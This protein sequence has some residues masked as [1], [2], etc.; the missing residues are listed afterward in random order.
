M[1]KWKKPL[2]TFLSASLVASLLVP[3]LPSATKAATNASDLIISEYIEGSSFNKAIELYNGTGKSINLSDYTL[4]LHTNGA[5]TADKKLS[6][7]GTLENGKTFV[8]HHNDAHAEIKGKGDLA[9][10]AVINFNGDD[11]VVL[12]KS[13]EVIDSIGQIDVK[14]NFATDVTLVRKSSITSGD[15][16]LNDPFDPTEWTKYLKDT[17]TNLGSHEMDAGDSTPVENKVEMV[18]A[19]T[20]S[21]SVPMDT[22]ITLS[23]NTEEATIYYTIDG[24]DPT[25]SSTKYT[26][27]VVIDKDVTIKAIAVANGLEN[28]EIATFEYKVLS[29]KTIAEVRTLPI[30]QAALTSGIVTAVFPGAINTTVYIQ[31]ETA[32]IVLYGPGLAVD[33]GDEV[34]VNGKLTEYQSL[35][36]LEVSKDD[37]TILGKKDVPATNLLSA[38]QLKEDKEGMLVSIKHVTVESVSSGNYTAKDENGTSF[39]IRPVDAAHLTIGTKY[40]SITGVLGSFKDTYQLLPRNVADI[41]EDATAVQPV[42]ATPGE[43][44]VKTGDAITLSSGTEDATIYYTTDGKQPTTDSKVYNEPIIITEDMTIKTFSMKDGVKSSVSTFAYAI[45]KGE[46]RIHDIQG[47]GHT[48]PYKDQNVTDIEGIITYVEDANNFY[49]QDQQ[50]DNDDNTSEGILVY[51]KAHNFKVGDVVK[52]SGQVKEFV[53]A[54]YAEKATTDLA[55]TEINATSVTIVT[56]GQTLPKP[57]VIGKDRIPPTEGIDSDGL[58][59]FNPE[60]DGIDFYESLEGMLVE[61]ESPK[62]VAPQQYGELVV[63][64]GNLPTNTTAGGL[65]FTETDANPER[66][67][68]LINDKNYV[69]K[70]GDSFNG[71]VTG[72]VSYS[73]SNYKILTNKDQLPNL[74]DGKTTREVTA[75]KEDSQKLSIASYNVENFSTQTPDSKVKNIAE[76]IINNLKKPDIIG[77]TEMQDND[78]ETDSGTTIANASAKKLTDKIKALGGPE[79]KYIDIAPEDKKDGGAPGGNIRVA[80]L[81]NPERVTLTPGTPGKATNSV[82]YK[83][84]KLTLNPGRIDP[85][86]SA[87]NS[88]RKPLAAQFEFQGKSVIVV[89]NHFNS[90][91]GDQPLFGKNQPPV[92]SSEVQRLKIASIVNNFVKGIKSQDANANVI[93]LGD[94][95]DFEFSKPLTTLKGNE[96]TNMIEKVPFDKRY[97][98]T[99]QGNSQV[100]DHILVS[101]NIAASTDVDIVH[102]NSSF[103]EQH[104][105]ASDHDPVLIQT[106]LS[107]TEAV[108]PIV[109]EKN[110]NLTNFKTKKLTIAS[111]SVSINLDDTSDIKE[112][113]LLTGAYAELKGLGLHATTVIVK[114]AKQ[115]AIID[116]KG[117]EVKEVI[118]DNANVK[119]IRGAENVQVWTFTDHVDTKGIKFFNMKG[120]AIASPFSKKENKAPIA[121][122]SIANIEVQAGSNATI[123]LSEYFAD[124]DGDD[125]TFSS[126]IGT[127]AGSTL[128]LPTN[129]AGTYLVA[130][131][132]M[133]QSAEVITRFTLTVLNE[134]LLEPY[135]QNASGKIDKEL[136][137]ALHNIIKDHTQL[138]YSQVWDA[139]K[140]TDEDPNN[141]NNVILLYSG[142][143]ISK[144]ANGGN[145]GQWNREHVWAKSHGDFG[146][147]KGPGTD[148]HHLRPADVQVNGARGHLDFDNGGKKYS[149]CDCYSDSDSWEPPNNVKGDIARM[150]FYMAVRYEGNGELDLE[151]SDTVNTYPKPLHGKLSTLLE[152][153]ELDP[154]DDFEKHRN[155]VIFEKWQHNRNPFVDHPEWAT[156]I[157]GSANNKFL[158]KAS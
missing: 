150:L 120:E 28:S 117:A 100:L 90:K 153:N 46:I 107:G 105:R 4:E 8:I 80:F 48:S 14:A 113:I 89:A 54:G 102:I 137:M 18:T 140:D 20:S 109:A 10:S 22:E 110:Y 58:E 57:V 152:W 12:K 84:G 141:S 24:T 25:I 143:S 49:I 103:M 156:E 71:S 59:V 124:P 39:I 139:I 144:N 79:Y 116:F 121:S 78:G 81:Y 82:E 146:T 30:G 9:N 2:N 15:K 3:T 29:S 42:F 74:V 37:I 34:K 104:G 33:L 128:T 52:V 149:G 87:Y 155:D 97:S 134:N 122:K 112:G 108:E 85:T 75:L 126:T 73:F 148:I 95:N 65:K 62:I 106:D 147:S 118:I 92:L 69:A 53:L 55:A 77:L 132:A 145:V 70:T 88:S 66:M 41:I 86:N 27:P 127:V 64:P 142:K 158:K 63:I 60:I 43:G 136:K 119:E 133:D 11:P 131:K 32:G 114:P 67:H 21:L 47:S 56:S 23:T 68:L 96:L 94:F 76:S 135:Y 31:D 98:Y 6:L 38:D 51:K 125:L 7:T 45:Q 91:G 19:S 26:T 115:G 44:F 40:D 13:D 17:F 61:I 72:V 50:P 35:L 5:I 111:P 130:V 129:E 154:V 83:D 138:S 123:D 1:R 151:L 16:I 99:Y 101:N 36:E 157:W 93:L